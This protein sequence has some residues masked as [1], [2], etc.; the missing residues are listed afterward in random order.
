MPV[1]DLDHVYLETRD[2]DAGVAFWEGLGFRLA[3]QWGSDGHRAGRLAAGKA[4]VVLAEVGAD[5][6]PETSIFF[7]LEDG[8]EYS[9][10]EAV[11]VEEQLAATH[12]GTRLIRVRDPEGRVFCLEEKPE[13]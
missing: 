13:D 10:A 8:D 1:T 3:E 9:V 12:W 4:A 5:S 11:P 2:W 6:V 7:A